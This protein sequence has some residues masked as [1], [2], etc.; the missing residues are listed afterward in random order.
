MLAYPVCLTQCFHAVSFPPSLIVI[1][2][3]HSEE[4]S[5]SETHSSDKEIVVIVCAKFQTYTDRRL[6]E[7]FYLFMSRI[8]L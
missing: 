8:L 7:L 5:F 3:I 1:A 2:Y 4:N 6:N